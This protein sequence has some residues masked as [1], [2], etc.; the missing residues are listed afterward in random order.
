MERNWKTNFGLSCLKKKDP[1]RDI[2][3]EN[4]KG[5]AVDFLDID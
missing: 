3:R 5:E 4:I 2:I 1:L